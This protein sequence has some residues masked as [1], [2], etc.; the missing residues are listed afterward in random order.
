MTDDQIRFQ[1]VYYAIFDKEYQTVSEIF[2]DDYEAELYI[3]KLN[4][5][6]QL[7]RFEIQPC[8]IVPRGMK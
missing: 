5:L 7:D 4:D 2:E 3:R 8:R 6:Y 1:P